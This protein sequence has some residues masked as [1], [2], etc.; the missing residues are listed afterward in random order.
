MTEID[1]TDKT[2]AYLGVAGAIAIAVVAVTTSWASVSRQRAL[3]AVETKRL[4]I[5]LERE[6][7]GLPPVTP[8]EVWGR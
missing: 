7:A 3:A 5:N 4:E 6:K 2:F 1:Q 8:K